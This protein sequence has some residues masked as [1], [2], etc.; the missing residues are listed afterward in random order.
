[1][2][3]AEGEEMYSV[4]LYS[5]VHRPCHVDGMNDSAAARSTLV[6]SRGGCSSIR[7]CYD[8]RRTHARRFLLYDR[9]PGL[10]LVKPRQEQLPLSNDRT[11]HDP[12]LGII[13][14]T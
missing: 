11:P 10:T 8:I 2:Q 14:K 6:S 5:R 3:R 12:K 4:D 1:M 13:P 9:R 7:S